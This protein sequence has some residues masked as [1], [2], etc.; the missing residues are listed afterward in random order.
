M[1]ARKALL[2]VTA[3]LLCLVALS[4]ASAAAAAKPAWT[5]TLTPL[6]TNLPPVGKAKCW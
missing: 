3:L 5:L 6:P 4:P 2:G 1:S